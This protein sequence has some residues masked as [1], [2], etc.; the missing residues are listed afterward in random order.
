VNLSA[1][2]VLHRAL[3]RCPIRRAAK[4]WLWHRDQSGGRLAKM[5]SCRDASKVGFSIIGNIEVKFK[6]NARIRAVFL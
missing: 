3:R 4:I 5:A 2:Q 6:A 1:P